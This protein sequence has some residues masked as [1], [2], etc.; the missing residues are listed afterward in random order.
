MAAYANQLA[1]EYLLDHSDHS[2]LR[3]KFHYHIDDIRSLSTLVSATPD[4]TL[5]FD[6]A[7]LLLGSL[8][9][10]TENDDVLA[11]FHAAHAVLK[12]DT[13]TTLIV[14]LPHPRETFAMVEC[15]RNE[16]EIPLQD[17]HGN[18]SGELKILWGNEDDTFD[19]IQQ[20]RQFTVAMQVTGMEKDANLQNIRQ[21]VPMR[22]FTAQEIDALARCAGFTVD[23]MVGA[24]DGDEEVAVNDEDAAFRLVCVLRK[25]P[26]K[27]E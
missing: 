6:T 3:A 16:W 15:T 24:L 9:H 1:D 12:D 10:L 8:Q 4:E 19:P 7:W 27:Q 26:S 22:L 21:V 23:A 14:E 18:E 17:E 5:K 25:I 11:C 2:T 13:D 20:V